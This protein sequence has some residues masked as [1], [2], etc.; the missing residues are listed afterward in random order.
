MAGCSATSSERGLILQQALQPLYREMAERSE[1]ITREALPVPKIKP[2]PR[3][4]IDRV[5]PLFKTVADESGMQILA[6]KPNLQ[7]ITGESED[8]VVT[9]HVRGQFFDFRTFLMG[10]GALPSLKGVEKIEIEQHDEFKE[11]FLIVRLAIE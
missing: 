5:A 2:L 8:M 6:I 9:V 11:F 3:G 10:A 7:S 1:N 4:A